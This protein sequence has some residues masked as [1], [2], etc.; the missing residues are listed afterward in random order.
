MNRPKTRFAIKNLI[1]RFQIYTSHQPILKHLLI[2]TPVSLLSR[3]G[4][5]LIYAVLANWFGANPEMDYLYYYWGIAVFLVQILSSASAYSILIPLVAEERAKS[6]AD[7]SAC[8][9]AIFSVYLIGMPGICCV[10]FTICYFV[11][12]LFLP[13]PDLPV[14]IAIGIVCGL[15]VFTISASIRWLLRAVLDAYQRFSLPAIVQALAVPAVV[16]LTYALKPSIGLISVVFALIISE[17]L[18]TI[19]LFIVC[20][21]SLEF[22]GLFSFVHAQRHWR[23]YSK[24]KQFVKQFFLMMGTSISAGANPVVDRGMSS[25]LSAGSVSKLDYAFRLCTIPETVTGVIMPVLLSHW[26]AI[27]ADANIHVLRQSVWKGVLAIVGV[28]GPIIY[29]FYFFR[30]AVVDV[31]YG[32][33][34][35]SEPERLHVASLLGIYLI[36]TLPRLI[37]RLLIRAHLSVQNVAFVFSATLVRTAFNPILNLIFMKRWGLEGIAL[38]TTLLSFPS[39][40][41]IGIAF[42]IVSRRRMKNM[43]LD[44]G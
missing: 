28:M 21:F 35:M 22:K 30:I 29:G 10:S 12:S 37:S 9:R 2:V 43:K 31:L 6:Q 15:A 4:T 39:M 5:L 8:L 19:S 7:A 23:A 42:L 14:S 1:S 38:S 41:Y 24:T 18:Q 25:S 40:V 32:H 44:A 13:R 36:G 26:S 11:S 3:G 33:G 20:R 34:A 17:L 27:S 16:G